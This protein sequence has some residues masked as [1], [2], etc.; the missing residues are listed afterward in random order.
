VS[1]TKKGGTRGGRRGCG[2]QW[3]RD[4]FYDERGGGRSR[5]VRSV[6]QRGQQEKGRSRKWE[7]LVA[8]VRVEGATREEAQ[9]LPWRHTEP[10]EW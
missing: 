9:G 1:S 3:L 2:S 10:G 4:D 8:R 6:H 7:E 5:V